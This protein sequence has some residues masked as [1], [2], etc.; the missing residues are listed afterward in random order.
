M[1]SFEL[2]WVGEFP[3]DQETVAKILICRASVLGNRRMRNLSNLVY[4]SDHIL[5][6]HLGADSEVMD[7][8]EA[9]NSVGLLPRHHWVHVTA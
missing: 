6:Q 7:E 8:A 3:N 5:L 4:E 9:E 2:F 1:F